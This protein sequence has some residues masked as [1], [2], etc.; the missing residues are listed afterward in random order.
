[1]C[2]CDINCDIRHAYEFSHCQLELKCH[3]DCFDAAAVSVTE[4][5]HTYFF[6]HFLQ[7]VHHLKH[8]F[9]SKISVPNRTVQ[10]FYRKKKNFICH[11][12]THHECAP[13]QIGSFFYCNFVSFFLSNSCWVT[14]CSHYTK[15]RTHSHTHTHTTF[16]PHF[17]QHLYNKSNASRMFLLWV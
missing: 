4:Q 15:T 2:D 10:R 13:M 17:T 16:R 3:N 1:M 5:F 12:I 11:F 14:A 9:D 8:I 6:L 7:F